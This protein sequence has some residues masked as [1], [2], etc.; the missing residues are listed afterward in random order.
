[1]DSAVC[2]ACKDQ[3]AVVLRQNVKQ[4]AIVNI[5][6]GP[7]FSPVMRTILDPGLRAAHHPYQ[8]RLEDDGDGQGM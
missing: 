3:L 1:M 4:R 7:M 8:Q 2:L 5:Q 6:L